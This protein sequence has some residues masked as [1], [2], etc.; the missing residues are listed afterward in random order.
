MTRAWLAAMPLVYAAHASDIELRIDDVVSPGF[1][2]KR[3]TAMISEKGEFDASIGELVA[4]GR[5]FRDVALKCK[6]FELNHSQLRCEQGMLNRTIPVR[7]AYSF[8]R[9][10]IDAELIPARGESWR[11][12]GRYLEGNWRLKVTLHQARLMHLVPLLPPAMPKIGAGSINGSIDVIGKESEPRSL[13]GDLTISSLA[14]SDESGLHAGEK[15]GGWVKLQASNAKSKWNWQLDALWSEG[16]AFWQ[17]LYLTGKRHRLVA[18]GEAVANGYE[19]SEATFTMPG[20]GDFAFV[21]RTRDGK[22]T[23]AGIAAEE[24]PL[25]SVYQT[26][27]KPFLEKTALNDLRTAGTVGFALRYEA[28]GISDINVKLDNVSLEDRKRRFA[29]F[30]VNADVPWKRAAATRGDI[31]LGGGEVFRVPLGEVALPLM[32]HGFSFAAPKIEIPLLDGKLKVEDF[33]ARGEDDAWRWNFRADLT[34]ISMEGLTR[35]LDVTTMRGTLSGTIPRVT[36]DRSTIAVDGALLVKVFDGNVMITDLKLFEPLGIAPRLVANVDMKKLDLDLLTRAYSFGNITGRVDVAV[37]DLE[38]V[39]WSPTRFNIALKSS[40]GSYPKKISQTAVENIS[41]LGGGSAAAA[42]QRSV[43]RFFEQFGY[44]EIG[45][46]CKLYN[47]VCEMGG[48]E[49]AA[50]G[51]TIVKGGGV[52][53][54][55]VLGYNRRVNWDELISRLKRITSSKP[56]VQ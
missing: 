26:I 32:L 40:D 13:S 50:G 27:L 41:A 10:D 33:T 52:P 48:I 17:P 20:I 35:A 14:F 7:F 24:L 53:Q 54:I 55:T 38:L 25:E 5:T 43:L 4:F 23:E 31:R 56:V 16:E 28:G 30:G 11:A 36:Y 45:W 49:P 29:V 22:L 21:G 1:T 46:S 44:S 42:I 15:I 34:P 2:I 39:D 12:T 6:R 3:M 51:Y 37:D 8:E 47:S 19:I 18:R 9:G